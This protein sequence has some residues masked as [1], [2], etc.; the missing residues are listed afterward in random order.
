M[1]KKSHQPRLRFLFPGKGTSEVVK[2]GR[3]S[4]CP[5]RQECEV[6]PSE[7]VSPNGPWRFATAKWIA[8]NTNIRKARQGGTKAIDLQISNHESGS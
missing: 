4:A 8:M 6:K 1:K 3:T 7:C 5:L 2:H